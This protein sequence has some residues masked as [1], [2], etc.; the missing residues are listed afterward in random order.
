[1]T[2]E[3]FL[4]HLQSLKFDNAFN[5]YTDRCTL[6]DGDDA[7]QVRST[8]LLD[9]LKVASTVGVDSLWIGRDLGY[10]GGRRTGLAFTDDVHLLSHTA[11]WGIPFSRPTVGAVV[12][13]RSA[14]VVWSMLREI[15][16]PIFLW[17]V[18]PLHPHKIGNFFSNRMHTAGER[19]AGV[20]ILEMLIDLT[21]PKRLVAVGNDA[22]K[23]LAS[24]SS[25]AE[26]SKVRHPSYG[27]QTQFTKELRAIYGSKESKLL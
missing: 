15:Q 10:R 17:N 3:N 27:G 4:A 21:K 18:F 1:M 13:E 5:P 7:A 22:Q 2:P 12:A 23:A 8:V 20:E 24:V 16:R 9:T 25:S 26:C 19:A 11:I 6:Y 14:T